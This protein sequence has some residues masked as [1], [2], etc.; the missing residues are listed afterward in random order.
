MNKTKAVLLD[1]DGTL[2]DT[3]GVITKAYEHA[4][5]THNG[6]KPT[7]EELAPFIHHHSAV[8]RGLSSHVEYDLWLTTYREKLGEDWMNAPLYD[9]CEAVLESIRAAGYSMAVVTSAEYDRTIEYLRHRGL[10]GYFQAVAGM[11]GGMRPKPDPSLVLE[12]L[13]LLN[14]RPEEAVMVGDMVVDIAA[15]HAAGVRCIAITHGF[16]TRE[17]LERA[18]A[19]ILADSLLEVQRIVFSL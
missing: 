7:W 17:E 9:N 18:G 16:T 6:R 12:A 4:V 15:A 13:S 3:V 5:E 1:L 11:R 8:H 2:R 19:D 10:D 14:C